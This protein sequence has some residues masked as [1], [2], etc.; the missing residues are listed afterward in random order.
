MS[1]EVK[2]FVLF[3]SGHAVLHKA[4][5]Y[6]LLRSDSAEKTKTHCS[7]TALKQEAL[8]VETAVEWTPS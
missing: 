3:V 2:S 7:R 5:D 1:Q 8:C 6:Y 4:E